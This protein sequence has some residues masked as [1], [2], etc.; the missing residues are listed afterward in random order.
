MGIGGGGRQKANVRHRATLAVKSGT[1]Y[2]PQAHKR[3]AAKL[4]ATHLT[5]NK[6]LAESG[7]AQTQA[8]ATY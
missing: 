8:H 4:H 1:G 2:S 5:A 3:M 7:V 6:A